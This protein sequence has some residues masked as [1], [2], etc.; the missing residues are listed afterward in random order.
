MEIF[1]YWLSG[2][3][4]RDLYG[5][6]FTY[7]VIPA[8]VIGFVI[9][10][11]SLLKDYRGR[12]ILWAKMIGG[13]VGGWILASIALQIVG[14]VLTEIVMIASAILTTVVALVR[15]NEIQP[16]T[17]LKAAAWGAAINSSILSVVFVFANFS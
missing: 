7:V 8:T 15:M 10:A 1:T 13:F 6:F 14:L 11:L 5:I 4:N 16:W 17:V 12:I 2:Q 9:Y 3:L